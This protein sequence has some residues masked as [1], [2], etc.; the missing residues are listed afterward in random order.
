M[1]WERRRAGK[2]AYFYRSIKIGDSVRKVY[3]GRGE[4][5]HQAAAA[6][7]RRCQ[8]RQEAK[9]LLQEARAGTHEADRLAKELR[10]WSEVLLKTWLIL[11]G[12]RKCRGQWWR[13]QHG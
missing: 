11:T 5:A 4:A 8:D 13:S 9:K 10:E 12:H 7:E 6:M 3:Y 2:G 1:A